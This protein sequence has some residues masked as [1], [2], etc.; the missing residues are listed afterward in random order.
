MPCAFET[1]SKGHILA[2]SSGAQQVGYDGLPHT[3]CARFVLLFLVKV[4]G[5]LSYN[6]H[7]SVCM[8]CMGSL[9]FSSF[10]SFEP[11]Y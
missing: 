10:G 4:V 6:I 1:S 11:W 5:V 9:M 8:G 7:I 2:R 3:L